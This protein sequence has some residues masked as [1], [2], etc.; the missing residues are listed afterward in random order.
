M[1][2]IEVQTPKGFR[3]FLPSS[4]A[5][6][7]FLLKKIKSTVEKFGFEPLETP[8]IEY[9]ETLNG[10]YGEE[11]KLIYEFTDRGNRQIALRYDLTV[12]LARVAA[13][14][15]DLTKP[16]KRYQAQS[17][18][19]AE[20]TQKG[21]FREFLQ[22]DFD[23][24]GAKD[25]LAD[26]EVIACA[27]T[28]IDNLGF[29]NFNM[30]VNDRSVFQNLPLSAI[31]S[32]DKIKKIGEDGVFL[33]MQNKG[34]SAGEARKILDQIKVNSTTPLIDELFKNL[35]ALGVSKEN[36]AFDPTLAR[37]LDYYTGAI[38]EL[39][40][41]GYTAGSV[42][43]GGRYDNLIGMFSEDKIP[44]VG[45]SFGF[46]RLLEAANEQNLVPE[47]S[48]STKVLVTIFSQDL[49]QD[50]LSLVSTLRNSGINTQVYL[51]P[52]AKL[53]KQI[54]YADNKK[55]PYVAILGPEEKENGVVTL[56]DLKKASQKQI[57]EAELIKTLREP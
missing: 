30:R 40:I 3:D 22:V 19:R 42:G 33:E 9:A 38:F 28:F 12:P 7:A 15:K 46:D 49:V 47:Y 55:I 23:T 24:V 36:F 45:F 13:Q 52:E 21:R 10:K 17:V 31:S 29:K 32:I 51:D 44:A 2:K 34:F 54:K 56:K 5:S 37:G 25:L 18:W 11:E 16:F 27:L 50:S 6:R 57:K 1:A 41:E 35:E 4:A 43:G 26:A 20:N 14:Y 53:D 39:E 8:A 48:P